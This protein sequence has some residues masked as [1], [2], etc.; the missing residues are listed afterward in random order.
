MTF[1]LPKYVWYIIFYGHILCLKYVA[2][3]LDVL[4]VMKVLIYL[5]ESNY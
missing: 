5:S 3:Y 1:L 4:F 2:R